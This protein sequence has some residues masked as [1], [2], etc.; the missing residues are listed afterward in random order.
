MIHTV[1]GFSIVNEAEVDVFLELPCF[2]HDPTNV[3]SLLS[4]SSASLKPSLYFAVWQKVKVLV[5]Q[6]YL[7]LCKPMDW[8]LSGHSVHGILQARILE[9][10]SS[11]LLWGSFQPREQACLSCVFC[12]GVKTVRSSP[13]ALVVTL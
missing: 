2:V 7:T 10:V 9:W 8:N 4:G 3:G 11:S 5:A 6:L 1:K 13:L 12:I